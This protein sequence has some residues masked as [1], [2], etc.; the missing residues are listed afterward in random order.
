MLSAMLAGRESTSS[1]SATIMLG[2]LR[3]KGSLLEHIQVGN[4][5]V[6]RRYTSMLDR[7]SE[8]MLAFALDTVVVGVVVVGL[9]PS[10]KSSGSNSRKVKSSYAHIAAPMWVNVMIAVIP[11][12]ARER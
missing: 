1:M 8:L 9:E 12:S 5:S 7:L 4:G 11:S 3:L 2:E 10:S 6:L